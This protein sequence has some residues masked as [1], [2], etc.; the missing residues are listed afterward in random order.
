MNHQVVMWLR[1]EAFAEN[2]CGLITVGPHDVSCS[3]SKIFFFD[4]KIS[5]HDELTRSKC[6]KCCGDPV[7]CI[8]GVKS[9]IKPDLN[10]IFCARLEVR[11]DSHIHRSIAL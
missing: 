5:Q 8:V 3:F 1:P 7:A 6:R 11:Y 10:V 2:D 4:Q 9:T